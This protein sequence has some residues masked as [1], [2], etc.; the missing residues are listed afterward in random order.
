MQ[1]QSNLSTSAIPAAEV[2]SRRSLVEGLR[3]LVRGEKAGPRLVFVAALLWAVEIFA[4]QE[5]TFIAGYPPDFRPSNL[6][7][8]RLGRF[9]LDFCF[10]L[11]M[12]SLVPRRL[13]LLPL[14]L[15]Q[16]WAAAILSYYEYFARPLSLQTVKSQL[17]EGAAV[18]G[19]GLAVLGAGG[20]A[21]LV[22]AF[23]LKAVL[24]LRARAPGSRHVRLG[25]GGILGW[26]AI[27]ALTLHF[28]PFRLIR[29]TFNFEKAAAAYGYFW[30]WIGEEVYFS[31]ALLEHAV[32]AARTKKSNRLADETPPPPAERVA[33]I[34]VESLDFSII[35]YEYEG[36]L[37]VPF[38]TSLRDRS[39]FYKVR[40]IHDNGSADADFSMLTGLAPSPDVITYRLL[41]YPYENTLPEIFARAGYH[42]EAIHGLYGSFFDRRRVFEGPMQFGAVIFQEEL[43]RD[44]GLEPKGWGVRDRD[45]MRVAAERLAEREGKV[46][47]FIITLSSHMPFKFIG[48]ENEEL[49]SRPTDLRL[50]YL[51]SIRYVDRALQD[52]YDRIPD[53]T[54]LVIYGDHESATVPL[55]VDENGKKLEYVPYFIHQKGRVLRSSDPERA[56][57]GSLHQLDLVTYIRNWALGL[58]ETHA[59]ESE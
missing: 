7:F 23:L 41:D 32:E 45:M 11:S 34:Q 48:A 2:H 18:A 10:A 31:R 39:A 27:S 22:G 44:Y 46:F 20:I 21:W 24:A 58:V 4:T 6:F 43:M 42:T 30:T 15:W 35:G 5:Y 47:Q 59:A 33:I 36:Q 37:V 26:I 50:R 38:L 55:P 13:V 29:T 53:G 9:L 56:L 14:L 40:P 12:L 51:N 25:L 1:R 8:S 3:A 54:L 52:Y 19:T 17:M 49:V 28:H 16:V 57:G